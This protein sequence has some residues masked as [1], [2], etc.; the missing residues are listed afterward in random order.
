MIIGNNA[1]GSRIAPALSLGIAARRIVDDEI[2]SPFATA[3]FTARGVSEWSEIPL[4]DGFHDLEFQ[5]K[6]AVHIAHLYTAL[7]AGLTRG[8][9]SKLSHVM[10]F[11]FLLDSEGLT[12][13]CNSTGAA[14]VSVQL[15]GRVVAYLV[16]FPLGPVVAHLRANVERIKNDVG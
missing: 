14:F 8:A 10:R 4:E 11:A 5:G 16:A 1:L 9:D 15:A 7:F 13:R 2:L 12:E 6:G 3:F